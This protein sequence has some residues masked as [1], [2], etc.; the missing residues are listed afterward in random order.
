[1]ATSA[2]GAFGIAKSVVSSHVPSSQPS[3]NTTI[4][5]GTI[6]AALNKIHAGATSVSKQAQN[7]F[8]SAAFEKTMPSALRG[9]L[10]YLFGVSDANTAKSAEL[11]RENRDWQ[12]AQNQIAMD[13][14]ASEAAKQRDWSEY[15]SNTAHQREIADL[16]AAGLNPVLSAMGGNGA[17]V[18]SGAAAHGVTSSG[19]QGQVD[20]SANSAIVSLL[21]SALSAQTQLSVQQNNAL[22]N[23]AVA[24][25]YTA[26]Q[27]IVAQIAAS[28]GI[29]QAQIHAG[30]SKY[31]SDINYQIHKDFPNSTVGA[32][33]SLLQNDL[34]S[35]TANSALSGFTSSINKA[36]DKVGEWWKDLTGYGLTYGSRRGGGGQSS[37]SGAG[38][39]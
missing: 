32:L 26:M 30:A 19:S 29:S 20:T 10:D 11:A 16:K 6:D 38:R 23:I 12:K 37:G 24:D 25:K 9:A 15:M 31:G 7:S 1:M 3:V 17:S 21:A 4:P 18:G 22:N 36:A 13:F 35:G 28:S 33:A 34:I 14:N 5:P 8:D 27:Q 2:R 39:N